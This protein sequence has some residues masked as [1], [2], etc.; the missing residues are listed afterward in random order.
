MRTRKHACM[1]MHMHTHNTHMRG[2]THTAPSRL[3]PHPNP[4]PPVTQPP[5][6]HSKPPPPPPPSRKPAGCT[7]SPPTPL[8]LMAAN[9]HH[10]SN[11]L[12]FLTNACRMHLPAPNPFVPADLSLKTAEAEA[13]KATGLVG[14]QIIEHVPGVITLWHRWVLYFLSGA[15]FNAACMS[16][17]TITWYVWYRPDA[18]ALCA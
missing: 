16:S 12:P 11:P 15:A 14:P 17:T 5:V 2:H 10:S 1:D 8:P 13:T 9:E 7:C 3:V 18:A 6:T 4:A